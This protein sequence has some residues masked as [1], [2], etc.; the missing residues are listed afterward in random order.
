[1]SSTPIRSGGLVGMFGGALWALWY[2]GVPLV[3]ERYESYETYNRLMPVVLLLLMAGLACYHAAQ[4]GLY[5]RPGTVGFIACFVGLVLM[6][7]GNVAEFWLFTT[8]AYAEA[9]GRQASWGVFLL[10]MLLLAIGSALFGV[11][12]MR[13]RVLPRLGGLLLVVWLPAGI[14]SSIFSAITGLLPTDLAFSL[15][16]AGT[17]GAA[18]VVLGY[19]MW[20]GRARATKRP[21]RVR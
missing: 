6:V 16:S 21:A 18:W 8:Q 11:A 4:R 5:G 2:V 15:G 9:N 17:L 19:A 1:M 13:A 10:G 7:V 12:T 14:L 3:G 20:S